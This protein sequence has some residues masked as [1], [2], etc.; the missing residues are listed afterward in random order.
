M[1]RFLSFLLF[2]WVGT[3]AYAAENSFMS[4]EGEVAVEENSANLIEI[5]FEGEP[6][7]RFEATLRVHHRGS[8]ERH[9]LEGTVPS[10]H[11]YHGETLEASV[12]QTSLEGGLVVVVRKGGNV[13]RSSTRG[14]NSQLRLQ[15]R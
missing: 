7:T 15:V 12:R 2:A 8:K 14:E 10:E 13:S 1:K 4:K 9:E 11:R 6:G 5:L 3:N